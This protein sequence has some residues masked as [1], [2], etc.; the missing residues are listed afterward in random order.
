MSYFQPYFLD[1]RSGGEGLILML[2]VLGCPER[3]LQ[4]VG[5]INFLE[6]IVD[7]GLDRVAAEE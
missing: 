7:M 6:D 1:G 2:E 5:Y 4:A 3:C